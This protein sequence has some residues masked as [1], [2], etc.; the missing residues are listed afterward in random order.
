MGVSLEVEVDVDVELL[1]LVLKMVLLLVL[2]D[3]EL[4]VE[5]E[6]DV[7]LLIFSL[8]SAAVEMLTRAMQHHAPI[9]TRALVR[10]PGVCIFTRWNGLPSLC[11]SVCLLVSS[12]QK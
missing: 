10:T 7:E 1:V 9:R 5:V 6:A 2:V 8:A 11:L 12:E 4:E 3:V